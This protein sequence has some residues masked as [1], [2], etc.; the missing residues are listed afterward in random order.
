[1]LPNFVELSMVLKRIKVMVSV[2]SR[3]LFTRLL[4][5][6]KITFVEVS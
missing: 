6:N 2:E 1:M 5:K 4:G 3:K